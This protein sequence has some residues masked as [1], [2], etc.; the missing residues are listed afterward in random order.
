MKLPKKFV[1]EHLMT[2]AK[3]YRRPI[4]GIGFM[5]GVYV[6]RNVREQRPV[7]FIDFERE[8]KIYGGL[9]DLI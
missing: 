6:M 8:I 9:K 3:K 5:W 1:D 2:L 4:L 7:S